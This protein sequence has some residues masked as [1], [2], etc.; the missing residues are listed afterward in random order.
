VALVAV[1]AT[2][3]VYRSERQKEL[4][5]RRSQYNFEAPMRVSPN[6]PGAAQSATRVSSGSSLGSVINDPSPGEVIGFS[7]YDE[8]H[9]TTMHRNVS[10][11]FG[12]QIHFTWTIG[13]DVGSATRKQAY[14]GYDP[15]GGQYAPS[16]IP[17]NVANP[18]RAGYGSI[19]EIPYD[20]AGTSG[21]GSAAMIGAHFD[22]NAAAGS[23]YYSYVYVQDPD[24]DPGSYD[25]NVMPIDTN[26]AYTDWVV[27]ASDTARLIWPI[28]EY[29][30]FGTDTFTYVLA[31]ESDSIVEGRDNH[32][33]FFRLPGHDPTFPTVAPWTSGF[34]MSTDPNGNSQSLSASRISQQV[35]CSWAFIPSDAEPV[36][37]YM[38]TSAN[39]G[40]SWSGEINV[41]NNPLYDP[42]LTNEEQSRTA[43]ASSFCIIDGADNIHVMWDSHVQASVGTLY[44]PNDIM[45]YYHPTG[46]VVL[47]YGAQ[48]GIIEEYTPDCFGIP[49]SGTGPAHTYSVSECNG[50]LYAFWS[51]ANAPEGGTEDDCTDYSMSA[52]NSGNNDVYM[53]VSGDLTGFAW[54]EARNLTQSPSAECDTLAGG[55]TGD[56]LDDREACA[57]RVGSDVTSWGFTLN[58]GNAPLADDVDPS[59]EGEAPSDPNYFLDLMYMEDQLPGEYLGATPIGEST[60]NDVKWFRVPCV[61]EFVKPDFNMNRSEIGYPSYVNHNATDTFDLTFENRGN[62]DLTVSS[63][64]IALGQTPP[65][66]WLGISGSGPIV[67]PFGV[68]R[69]RSIEVYLND[70]QII[71]SPG[72]IVALNGE[73]EI[74]SDD[75]DVP[76]TLFRIIDYLVADTIG[77]IE[78]DT[79]S[80]GC[81]G[82]IV[83]NNGNSGSFAGDGAD[84][85]GGINL[86][87]WECGECDTFDDSLVGDA[88]VYLFDAAPIIMWPDT[89]TDGLDTIRHA[90]TIFIQNLSAPYTFRPLL[91]ETPAEKV[92]GANFEMYSSGTMVTTDSTIGVEVYTY[93]PTDGVDINYMIQ[94]HRVFSFD[95]Q[96]HDSLLI[97]QLLDWDVPSDSSVDNRSG[98]S[99]IPADDYAY[100]QGAEWNFDENDCVDHDTRYATCALVGWVSKDDVETFHGHNDFIANRVGLNDDLTDGGGNLNAP[101]LWNAMISDTGVFNV[102]AVDD[103]YQVVST[104][105]FYDL[106]SENEVWTYYVLATIKGGATGTATELDLSTAVAAGRAWY[107]ANAEDIVFPALGC[108]GTYDSEGLSGNVDFDPD[109]FKDISDI[110]ML[111]RYS[112]LGGTKPPCIA[113]ANV[114][115]DVDCFTDISDI[116]RLARYS[117]LGGAAPAPCLALCEE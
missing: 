71:N 78:F 76:D 109:N 86:D 9:N 3:K 84:S 2:A 105:V 117:L 106:T 13:L 77:E 47:V 83:G 52:L 25:G 5:Q 24:T 34:I 23:Q 37:I 68:D 82:L 45:H 32:L 61:G 17:V 1:S 115:G 93:A 33:V 14:R 96:P 59:V 65:S 21:W 6:D 39:M 103:L 28:V 102:E 114:D 94:V 72:T 113:E 12:P 15:R 53:S 46:D 11:R 42:D 92:I 112:L 22:Q 70:G 58:F 88:N 4:E 104:H 108:C 60:R 30:A 8:F 79:V 55:T 85:T 95:G 56:C 73:L 101:F 97:G 18:E 50:R 19:A 35:A 99:P 31:N 116:L 44:F 98:L 57:Q 69:F 38:R 27:E 16:G 62:S 26:I 49:S 74:T 51:M 41:S 10:S 100:I 107:A 91:G 66:P 63:I 90:S 20:N 40:A 80:T 67:V 111:A 29:H 64:S 36:Q 75:P 89:G 43:W 87:F 110:L 48:W 81:I 7:Y 54:D